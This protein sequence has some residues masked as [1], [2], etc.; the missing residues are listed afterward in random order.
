MTGIDDQFLKIRRMPEPLA[1]LTVRMFVR[2]GYGTKSCF[3]AFLT[4]PFGHVSEISF[5]HF[6][7]RFQPDLLELFLVVVKVVVTTGC[8]RGL[9]KGLFCSSR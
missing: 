9:A 2:K 7:S 3:D 5:E 6:F 4:L 8:P 1:G